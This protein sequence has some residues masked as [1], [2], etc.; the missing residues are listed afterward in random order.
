MK[1]FLI[2]IVVLMCVFGVASAQDDKLYVTAKFEQSSTSSVRGLVTNEKQVPVGNATIYITTEFGTAETKSNLEG[3]FVYMLPREP[4]ADKFNTSIKVQKEG[5]LSGYANIS[6][7]VKNKSDAGRLG[8]SFKILT[9][10]KIREDPIALKILQNIEENKQQEQQRLKK[11]QEINERQ[12][13]IEEQRQIANENLLKDLGFWFEQLDPF[14][15]RNA[16][17][18]FVSQ[19]DATVQ[20]IYWAQFNFTETKTKEGL[21]ALQAVLESGGTTQEARRAFYEKAATPRDELL[22]LNDEFN[23]NYTPTQNNTKP[24]PST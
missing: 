17:A 8:S 13:F 21:E 10:D 5:Y 18:S 24:K 11:L 7:F 16:F 22:R 6:F 23:A 1:L 15:P 19:M 2:L 20:G 14:N 9:A 4:T 12:K 3:M